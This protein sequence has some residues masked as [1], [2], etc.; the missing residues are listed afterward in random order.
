MNYKNE[1]QKSMASP[2]AFWREQANKIAWYKE[3][4]TILDQDE[5][6]VARWFADGELNT[7][8]LALDYHVE[9]GRAEQAALIYDSPVTGVTEQFSYR[10]LRDAVATF[11][12]AMQRRGIQ[13]GDR[14]ILYMP[15]VPQ[16]VM[17]ML[18]CARLGAIHSV[19]FGGFAAMELASRIDDATPK[20]IVTASCGIEV[21]RIIE[22]KPIVDAARDMATHKVDCCVVLQRA[23]HTCKLDKQ[24]D[25]DWENFI[26]DAE[27]A[28]C[29]AVMATDPLYI[30]YTSGITGKPK[31]VVRDNGGHGVA[32]RY[33][34]QA[35]YDIK[36][37]DVFW[38]ASDVGWVVGHSY[39]VYAPLITGC[40]TILYEGK[41]V[42]TPDAGAF[43]RVI[44]QH[45]VNAVFAAPTA[46]RAI[47][48]EDPQ[49]KLL[50]RYNL[51]CLRTVF[52]AGERTDPPTWHWLETLLQKPIVDHWW[53]TETG[54]AIAANPVGIEMLPPKPGSATVPVPGYDVR[55]LDHQGRRVPANTP[56]EIVIHLPLPPGCFPTIWGNHERYQKSYL[57]DYPGYYLTGDGGYIDDD[58]YLFVMGRTDDVINV[59]GHRLSTGEMEELIARH[60]AVAECAV[61]GVDDAIKGQVP[62]ALVVLKSGIAD[63]SS[64]GNEI[65]QQMRRDKGAVAALK[66]VLI[67]KRLPK[68]RSGKILRK[69]LRQIGNGETV[70]V[71]STIDDPAI[72]DEIAALFTE[73]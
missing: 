41:P 37:G 55:V 25:I 58:G 35:I 64:I 27:P 67:A 53:Q 39:I 70:A 19:V 29:V 30:L 71:P 23:Q 72:L 4:A 42:H 63:V 24:N 32:L 51:A 6:H 28:D 34:M 1:Y 21:D 59:A 14:V 11:A 2:E 49:G 43:W 69:T 73:K 57:E 31:G 52:L 56:G 18:A 40:T 65:V 47:R 45:G 26:A 66:T 36:P 5:N 50:E 38:A 22:Y 33:S 68:T 9:H 61:L 20:M 8:W 16:A 48:K 12:G 7:A 60:P 3:P 44:E 62:V 46:F 13:K 15:M 54:W 17:A 10:E